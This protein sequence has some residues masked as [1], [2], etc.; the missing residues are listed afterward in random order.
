MKDRRCSRVFPHWQNPQPTY[1]NVTPWGG[2]LRLRV[3]KLNIHAA[4]IWWG[5]QALLRLPSTLFTAGLWYHSH[6]PSMFGPIE[7]QKWFFQI[8]SQWES[9]KNRFA[10]DSFGNIQ[11]FS[12]YLPAF[13]IS[14]SCRTASGRLFKD[15]VNGVTVFFFLALHTFYV[16]FTKI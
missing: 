12:F 10:L 4:R 8:S 5:G 3:F 13:E 9:Q 6:A 16:L 7:G 14:R 1:Q 15:D 2:E 11:F